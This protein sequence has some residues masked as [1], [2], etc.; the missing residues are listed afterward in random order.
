[1]RHSLLH[2]TGRVRMRALRYYSPS[3]YYSTDSTT[4]SNSSS[5]DESNALLPRREEFVRRRLHSEIG[6]WASGNRSND[7]KQEGQHGEHHGMRATTPM[8][9]PSTLLMNNV[10]DCLDDKNIITNSSLSVISSIRIRKQPQHRW[11]SAKPA[12]NGTDPTIDLVS[13]ST[14]SSRTTPIAS[15]AMPI[16][17][18]TMTMATTSKD[19]VKNKNEKDHSDDTTTDMANSTDDNI[20]TDNSKEVGWRR[21]RFIKVPEYGPDA[22]RAVRYLQNARKEQAR[23]KTSIN[24]QRALY[25]NM[26]I[27]TAKL[28]AW[29][30]SGS[31]SM[32]A[33][34]VHSV[35][36]CG[37]QA[38]LMIG[39]RDTRHAA[40]KRHPYGY[41]KSV[42]FWALVS[43]LGTFFLGAGVSMSHSVQTLFNPTLVENINSEVWFVLAMSFAVDGYV[44]YK[45]IAG[46]EDSR[47]KG[48]PMLKYISKL[49]DPATLAVLLEDG[50]ACLGIVIAFGGIAASHATSNPMFDGLAGVGI[51]CLLGAVG[52]TLARVNHSFLIGQGVEVEMLQGIE[53]I[54]RNRRSIENVSGIQSQWTGPETFSY[55]AEVDFDG[56]YLS[57]L[58]MPRYRA[59]FINAGDDLDEELGVLLSWYAEDVI[60]AVERE[61]RHIEAIIRQQ[62]P[63]AE[64]IELEPMSKF[65]DRF[66]IDDSFEEKLLMIEKDEL[67][68]WVHVLYENNEENAWRSLDTDSGSSSSNTSNNNVVSGSVPSDTVSESGA[69]IDDRKL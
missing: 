20:S 32:M 4:R 53:K 5:T 48:M 61:V 1:M 63:G 66:A 64:Y 62:Y 6:N 25:G 42:Y 10:F 14:L 7:R 22:D 57:A 68:K 31:S 8:M 34:F 40:D 47:P 59:E 17:T 58:L 13:P 38:L 19:D 43:A 54:I 69:S 50:A 12:N 9:M 27:C 46:V 60:R 36:D 29:I 24:V 49:R 52:L 37:N 2:T 55:K 26:I 21:V 18:S 67:K 45:T 28:G 16:K 41:G 15:M 65:V 11:Y 56:T 35:V 3:S 44:L 30:S 39:L 33:E 23:V 51:S